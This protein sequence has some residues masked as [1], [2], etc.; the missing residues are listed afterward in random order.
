[1]AWFA[2]IVA[3]IAAISLATGSVM[4]I[5]GRRFIEEFT[6]PGITIDQAT[7]QWGGAAIGDGG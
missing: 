7:P 6:R 2:S 3:S 4:L 5:L 1:M